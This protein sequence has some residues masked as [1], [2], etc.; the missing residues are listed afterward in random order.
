MRRVA[1]ASLANRPPAWVRNRSFSV[2]AL[3]SDFRCFDASEG[4]V[5][6]GPGLRFPPV[7]RSL[8]GRSAFRFHVQSPFLT[9]WGGFGAEFLFGFLFPFGI[10]GAARLGRD[11]PNVGFTFP[12]KPCWRLSPFGMLRG[13]FMVRVCSAARRGCDDYSEFYQGIRFAHFARG[14]GIL[15]GES[16]KLLRSLRNCDNGRNSPI[17]TGH[18]FYWTFTAFHY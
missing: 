16:L 14:S 17:S 9:G 15:I 12:G 11:G 3:R 7:V 8:W 6:L 18:G 4:P 10:S 2:S 1:R 5:C 13:R